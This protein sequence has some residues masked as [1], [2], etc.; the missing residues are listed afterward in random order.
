MKMVKKGG[1]LEPHK[2]NTGDVPVK[3]AISLGEAATFVKSGCAR[4]SRPFGACFSSR[5]SRVLRENKTEYAGLAGS[6][7]GI[8]NIHRRYRAHAHRRGV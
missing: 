5:S 4:A 8:K 1:S 7:R 6:S 2:C 3:S